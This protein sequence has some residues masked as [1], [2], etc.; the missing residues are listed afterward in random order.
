VLCGRKPRRIV[1]HADIASLEL[2]HLTE[3]VEGFT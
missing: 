1:D 2:D 3:P